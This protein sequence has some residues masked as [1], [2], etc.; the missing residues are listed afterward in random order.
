VLGD[1][2]QKIGE[3]RCPDV[4]PGTRQQRAVLVD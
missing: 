3:S 1:Q 4:D 2:R